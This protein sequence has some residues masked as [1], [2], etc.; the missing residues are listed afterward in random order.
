MTKLYKAALLATLGLASVS[1]AHASLVSNDL[2]LGLVDTSSTSDY[3]INLGLATSLPLNS[4]SVVDLS[5]DLSASTFN[6]VFTSGT[7]EM[8]VVGGHST[9]GSYQMYYTGT[10]PNP[11]SI[12]AGTISSSWTAINSQAWPSSS[13]KSFTSTVSLSTAVPGS[14]SSQFGVS[15]IVAASS[16]VI[17]ENLYLATPSSDAYLGYFTLNESGIHSSSVDAG[18]L[19]FTS[20]NVTAVPEPATYGLLAGAGLLVVSLRNQLRRKQ[21]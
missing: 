14:F 12:T 8:G 6:S 13:D 1:A 3:V 2:Y 16:G 20:A 19:T 4:T 15:P 17:T 9:I 11:Q 10:A 21:A 5:G 7:V 18:T